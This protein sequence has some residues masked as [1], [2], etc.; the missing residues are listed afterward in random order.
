VITASHDNAVAVPERST[1]RERD[2]WYVFKVDGRRANLTQVTI[3]LKNDTWAEV[4]EGLTENDTIILEPKNTLY[5]GVR[6][7]GG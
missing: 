1:F 5:D 7:T 4:T 2:Q 3:G 6:V